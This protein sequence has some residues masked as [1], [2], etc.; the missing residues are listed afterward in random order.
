MTARPGSVAIVVA[1][2]I[3]AW[4]D[5]EP[6]DRVTVL[7][8][9]EGPAFPLPGSVDV[10]R[11][12]PPVGGPLG[13]AWLRTRALTQAVGTVRADAVLAAAPASGLGPVAVP[14]AVILYDL[15]HEL[16]PHQFSRRQRLLRRLTWLPSLSRADVI[17]CISE[18]TRADLTR[19][20][21]ELA[22]R[23]VA[24]VLGS[25][26]VESWPRNAT[27]AP[28][29][30]AF[31]HF[32]HK[33][34]D[35]VLEGW[36]RFCAQEPAW[37]LRVV[38]LGGS[39]R[40]QVRLRLAELGISERVV[41]SEWLDDTAFQEVFA[42]AGMILFPSDFEGFGL[43]AA[44]ALRLGIP[45]VVS[46]DPAL[47]EVTGGYAVTAAS[48]SPGDLAE[49]MARAGLLTPQ[50][51]DEGRHY[52]QEFRWT[53]A[54][55]TLRA[56]LATATADTEAPSMPELR[57][58]PAC[59]SSKVRIGPASAETGRRTGL[60]AACGAQY[61]SNPPVEEST[62]DNRSV[63]EVPLEYFSDWVSSKRETNG[64]AWLGELQ[65]IRDEVDGDTVRLYD[66]GA[67]DGEFLAVARDR[68]GFEVTGND[69]VEAAVRLAEE[70][71]DL[72]LDFGDLAELGHHA[73][74]DAVTMW[75]VL[76]HVPDGAQ[77]LHDVA[78]M[79]RPGGLLVMQTPHRT[80]ADVAA[81]FV[82]RITGGRITRIADRR[83]AQHHRI[84]HT[85][86]SITLALEAAG[87]TDVVAT[88][89]R[90][91]SLQSSSYLRSLRVPEWTVRPLGWLMDRVISSRLA[92][93]IVLDVRAR[94]R[95]E[96][97]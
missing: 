88:P 76:A 95:G 93:A 46:T 28:Y 79:L 15:R 74:Q 32:S 2:L 47:A 12:R 92:P 89:V 5:N 39:A 73:D 44:E 84:L 19:L 66:V 45:V 34:V 61:W 1:H 51:L 86:R 38:G 33:N 69:I 97:H 7:T 72:S 40:A 57:V 29:A 22:P 17:A 53:R 52:A 81:A 90:R 31:G 43:P 80:R 8:G 75:C 91:Y 42:S 55:A 87:F 48:S 41:L 11:A 13:T 35:A 10:V 24:M 3:P 50:E 6:G 82:K 56:A 62:T 18:R 36:A 65:R 27:E 14:R 96:K 63:D 94:R 54:A 77:L 21:P 58:C 70:R 60:C 26:H 64:D 83:L 78:Q 68:F 85:R 30:L 20:H 4:L 25:D 71:Y 9:P 16:R 49:A 59:H 37:T 67:G 23:A